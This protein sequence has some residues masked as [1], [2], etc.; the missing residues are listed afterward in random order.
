[1]VFEEDWQMAYEMNDALILFA[2]YGM[3]VLGHAIPAL[4]LVAC[5]LRWRIRRHWTLGVLAMS[6]MLGLL[7]ITSQYVAG[8]RFMSSWLGVLAQMAAGVGGAGVL[9][10][11]VVAQRTV[12]LAND[13]TAPP[14]E[15]LRGQ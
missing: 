1:M 8:V 11:T 13:K 2:W 12:H 6:L 7:G 10:R 4:L 3:L 14:N 15:R 9:L 5:L